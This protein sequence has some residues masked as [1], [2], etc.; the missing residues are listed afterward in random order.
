MRTPKHRGYVVHEYQGYSQERIDEQAR[1]CSMPPEE[2]RAYYAAQAHE[3][4][5]ADQRRSAEERERSIN[6]V[7]DQLK[8]AGYPITSVRC[9]VVTIDLNRLIAE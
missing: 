3:K 9:G 7:V 1:V 2:R 4:A 5:I 6:L 8:R